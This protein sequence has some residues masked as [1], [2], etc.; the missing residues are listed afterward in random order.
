MNICKKVMTALIVVCL[1]VNMIPAA[2]AAGT[3]YAE[4]KKQVAT[5]NGLNSY[6]YT[7]QTWTPLKEAVKKGNTI[8]KGSH[9]Q[10]TVDDAALAIENAMEAL[11]KMDYSRLD[12]VLADIY[13]E[14]EKDQVRFDLWNRVNKAVETAR[15]RLVSGNQELVDQSVEELQ[16]LMDELTQ[17]FSTAPESSVMIQ[18]VEV[19]VL[20]TDDYC[21]IPMHRTWPILFVVSAVLNVAL[22]V[23][24][25]YVILR[26]R[27]TT[28]NTPLVS[29][30]I[31]DDMEF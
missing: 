19:E 16:A 21:N 24:L 7:V 18:E 1:F 29:Y 17:H 4:L 11:E 3:D 30:D 26:K 12:A 10:K 31:D 8:L 15:P 20:P 28:D 14:I 22:I 5:A 27:Q 9:G 2:L 13:N 25:T 6:E 23:L